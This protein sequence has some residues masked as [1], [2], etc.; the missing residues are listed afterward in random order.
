MTTLPER[1]N[2]ALAAFPWDISVAMEHEKTISDVLALAGFPNREIA[3]GTLAGKYREQDGSPTGV[4]YSVNTSMPY[5]V[6]GPSGE[7]DYHA[8][9]WLNK[10]HGDWRTCATLDDIVL[11][12]EKNTP[13]SPIPLTK[14]GD[15]LG[16][17]PM[18]EGVFPQSHRRDH[19]V[20][21]T[22]GIGVHAL[23]RGFIDIMQ[24]TPSMKV[25]LC[26]R[27]HLRLEFPS[28]VTTYGELRKYFGAELES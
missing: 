11:I 23:C 24:T 27:C 16:E 6:F 7:H 28:S 20:M 12:L 21:G 5:Y 15:V 14:V 17:F 3:K 9:E 25:L 2:A 26:R 1:L 4:H 18:R 13:L 10:V 8:T 19:D 22:L